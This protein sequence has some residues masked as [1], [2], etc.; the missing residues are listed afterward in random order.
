MEIHGEC[1][2]CGLSGYVRLIIS[3][4]YNNIA[5]YLIVWITNNSSSQNCFIMRL[6]GIENAFNLRMVHAQVSII[7]KQ[8]VIAFINNNENRVRKSF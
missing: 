7:L 5:W 8:P 6:L 1:S 2:L 4:Q 3:D